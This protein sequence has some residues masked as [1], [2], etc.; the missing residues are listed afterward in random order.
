MTDRYINPYR[1]FVGSFIPNW[2][3]RCNDIS[4][5]AKLV[6]ARLCQFAGKEGQAWPS[7]ATLAEECGIN[8]RTMERYLSELK[9]FGLIEAVRRGLGLTNAYRFLWHP[10]MEMCGDESRTSVVSDPVP[11]RGM[12]PRQ[13]GD[14]TTIGKRIN[15]ENQRKESEGTLP[16]ESPAFVTAWE[17]WQKYRRERKQALTPSTIK[18]QLEKLAKL[19]ESDAIAVIQTSIEKG[20][21]GLFPERLQARPR[22]D[23]GVAGCPDR[24]LMTR[25]DIDRE[26]ALLQ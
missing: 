5:E 11:V 19:S 8:E 16:F 13:C 2:L 4:A 24:K 21:Q 26:A 18:A 15:E 20:W 3:L 10:L 6:Y 22:E 1:L 12:T 14:N 17:S 25:E 7:V 23:S 9:R